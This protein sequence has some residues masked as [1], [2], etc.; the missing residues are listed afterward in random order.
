MKIKLLLNRSILGLSLITGLT[1]FGQE[2]RH[3]QP[4]NTYAAMEEAFAANPG[5]KERYEALQ[6]TMYKEYLDYSANRLTAKTAAPVYTIPVVFH[7]L[8]QG[9]AENISDATVM[10]AMDYINKDF[11]RTNTDAGQTVAP[12]NTSYIDSEIKFMLAKKD[13]NGNCTN[14]IVR[15]IDAKTEWK[16][17]N[18]LTN[19]TYTWDPTKYMNIYIVKNIVPTST[20]TGGGIIVGYTFKPNTWPTGAGQDAIV[21]RYDFLSGGDNPRSLTHEI[22]HW[23]NL[24]HTWGNTNNPGVACGDDGITDTPVTLGEFSSCPSS[25]ATACTQTNVAMAGLNNVQNIMNYSSCPRNFTTGQTNAMRAALVS[26][27]S[28][29]N[30][31]WSAGNLTFTDI[32]AS[33]NCAPVA[34][35][36]STAAGDYTLCAGQTLVTLKDFSYN[37]TVTSWTWTATNGATL[38]APNSSV[39]NATFPN[40]GTSIVTLSVTNGQGTGSTSRNITVINGVATATSG[41]SESFEGSGTPANW[42]VINVSGGV[43]WNQTSNA[44]SN[45]AFSFMLDGSVS[46]SLA[47]DIL[48][49]PIMDFAA[50]PGALLT[51]KYAYR[52]KNTT[53]NDVFKVQLSDNCGAS[54]KDV[55]APSAAVLASGSGGTGTSNFIPTAAEWKFQDVS[56]HP[57][58]FTFSA[59]SSVIGRFYFQEANGGF[60][61]KFYL[62]EVNFETPNGVNEMTAHLRLNLYPNPTNGTAKLTFVLSNDANVKVSVVDVTGKLVAAEKAYNLGAGE[63]SISLNENSQLQKGIYL[64]N[65]E[66]NGTKMA[67]KLIVE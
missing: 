10:A 2:N 9:G 28:G 47:E 58:F 65:M 8:H 35:F 67:R 6:K 34:D 63:H 54:W 21:Y 52:R 57:N 1:A 22:G 24:S 43:T 59:S 16:Q 55:Y 14:G 18:N 4:C 29:R 39:T 37:G 64:V 49:M 51:F 15:H 62:D 33:G 44:G 23:L 32:N 45:G 7:I 66:Y 27:N 25:S 13:P 46:T 50:N 20:V 40:V 19:Y 17:A 26:S 60:G 12:F 31:L 30:N 36:M 42:N 53:H 41:F 61:N 38:S 5:S 3:I 11:A 48:D 56:S